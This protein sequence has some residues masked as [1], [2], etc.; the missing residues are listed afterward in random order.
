MSTK[1]L[2][3]F[4]LGFI[5]WGCQKDIIRETFPDQMKNLS[6]VNTEDLAAAMQWYE[7]HQIEQHA[8]RSGEKHPLFDVSIPDWETS[9]SGED[10]VCKTVEICLN[11]LNRGL[12]LTPDASHAYQQTG[13]ERYLQMLTRL[14][15]LTFKERDE[16][17]G[18][19][20]TVVPSKDYLEKNGFRI[21]EK[22]SYTVRDKDLDGYVLYHKL[23]GDFINGWIY[24]KG[25]VTAAIYGK[26]SGNSIQT[27]AG[28][29]VCIPTYSQTCTDWYSSGGGDT[30]YTGTTCDAPV[31]EGSTCYSTGGS[32]S[33]GGGI[34]DIGGG[35]GS[36]PDLNRGD[37]IPVPYE[38]KAGDKFAKAN[39]PQTMKAQDFNTC[40]TTI[41]EYIN[42][43]VF[44]GAINRNI[45]NLSYLQTYGLNVY[46]DGV[47]LQNMNVFVGS[48]F[49]ILNINLSYQQAINEGYVIMTDIPLLQYR[50]CVVII[51][52]QADGKY[53][54]MN[55][56]DGK[57]YVNKESYFKKYFNFIITGIK[58]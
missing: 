12:F 2:S 35:G 38:K 16:V 37:T 9:L 52:Y 39:L 13:D 45:Y 56:E 11:L 15:V 54:Y 36:V 18:F 30:H 6:E 29:M 33:S 24:E 14:V 58:K 44:G 46:E 49:N 17:I 28:T 4:F 34:G 1:V 7:E 21:F 50:H 43:N 47:T 3:L 26:A 42:N 20:M 57:L 5:A 19:Y 25:V 32:G 23:D 55:P 27:R 41:M 53:I 51:G 48:F 31:Y 10:G 22:N 40:V 8:T